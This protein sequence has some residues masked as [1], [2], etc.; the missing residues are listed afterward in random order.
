MFSHCMGSIPVM[1][2][3]AGIVGAGRSAWN[4]TT[5]GAS[6]EQTAKESAI[7]THHDED[8]GNTGLGARRSYL[9][10]QHRRARGSVRSA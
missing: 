5:N 2:I 10:R 9:E 1:V 7:S 3:A 8:R 6:R 4:F